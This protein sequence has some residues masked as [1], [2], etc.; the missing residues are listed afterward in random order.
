M[1]DLSLDG[2][3]TFSSFLSETVAGCGRVV[4]SCRFLFAP[5]DAT[6]QGFERFFF[7]RKNMT[8]KLD[9]R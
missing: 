7:Q 6:H 4:R 3:E 8:I 5:I 9:E 1:K 2:K